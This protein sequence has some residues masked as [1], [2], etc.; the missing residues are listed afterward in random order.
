MLTEN[1]E[2]QNTEKESFSAAFFCSLNKIFIFLHLI[3]HLF[4]IFIMFR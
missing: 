2:E 1:A 4:Y 3:F